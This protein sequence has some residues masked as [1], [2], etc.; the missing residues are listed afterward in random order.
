MAEQGRS[1][2]KHVNGLSTFE[3]LIEFGIE[4]LERSGSINFN[5]ETV[6]RESGVSRGSLYHHFGSRHGLIAHCET[7][8]LKEDWDSANQI[9]RT[10]IE[11]ERTGEQLFQALATYIRLLGSDDMMKQ[12]SKRI[13]AIAVSMDDEKLFQKLVAAQMSGSDFLMNSYEIARKNDRIRPLVDMKA[14]VY[15]TQSMALGRVLVDMTGD[16]AL[17]DAVN[18]ANVLVLRHLMNP[19]P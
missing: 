14:L 4:E 3:T 15:L 1:L 7:E 12:R 11:S 18:E 19:Q 2:R 13:R 10:I 8:V 16:P 9:I 5:L 17:S 6:L